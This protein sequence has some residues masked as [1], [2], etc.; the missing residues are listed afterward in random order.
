[1]SEV[2]IDKSLLAFLNGISKRLF[3]GEDNITDEFLRDEVLQV[4]EEGTGSNVYSKVYSRIFF[5]FGVFFKKHSC[6]ALSRLGRF[7]L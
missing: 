4:T 5:F 2:G 6:L 3:F 1:M 7:Y